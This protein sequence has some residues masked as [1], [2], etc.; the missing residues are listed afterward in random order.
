[1]STPSKPPPSGAGANAKYALL[2]LAFIAGAVGLYFLAT[3]NPAPEE[4]P[5]VVGH[6]AGVVQGPTL[7]DDLVIPDPVPDA[8]P[9]VDSGPVRRRIVYVDAPGSSGDWSECSGEIAR[10]QVLSV[11]NEGR[12]GVTACYERRL[13]SNNTLEGNVTVK[14]KIG[15]NGAVS[16]Q[17]VNG[18]LRDN[19]VFSCI[20]ALTS[21]W[22]FPNPTGG[23]AVV[24]A[25]FNFT[26]H[27]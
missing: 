10:A 22:H 14:L 23:C 27:N 2:G 7:G 18:T 3:C 11:F 15:T 1:M 25:P 21:R 20:R 19:E 24:Q 6:D 4:A 5:V 17:Q 26:R 13:K 8:G 9:P 12:A 16:G